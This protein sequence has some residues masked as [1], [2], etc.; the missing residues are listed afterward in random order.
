MRI[1]FAL[2][3]DITNS[4]HKNSDRFINDYTQ[5]YIIVLIIQYTPSNEMK[6]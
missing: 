2:L 5:R 6:R 1:I 4:A 3:L